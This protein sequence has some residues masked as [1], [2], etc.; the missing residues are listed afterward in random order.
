[1]KLFVYQ[2]GDDGYDFQCAVV[3]AETDE[4]ARSLLAADRARRGATTPIVNSPFRN[5][6]VDSSSGWEAHYHA[7]NRQPVILKVVT[8]GPVVYTV[9]VDG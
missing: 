1:M 4:E 8:E 2:L 6:Q 7:L 9:G 5:S 3:I